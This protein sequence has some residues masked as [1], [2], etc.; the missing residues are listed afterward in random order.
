MS[1]KKQRAVSV[2]SDD[3]VKQLHPSSRAR[4]TSVGAD[5][6]VEEPLGAGDPA[7]KPGDIDDRDETVAERKQREQ[8]LLG[9]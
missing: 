8:G 4:I 7:I 6:T 1:K 5:P 2:T 9:E 3:L